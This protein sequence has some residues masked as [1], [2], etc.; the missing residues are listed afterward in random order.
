MTCR[1]WN[2]IR[3]QTLIISCFRQSRIPKLK[4]NLNGL[5]KLIGFFYRLINHYYAVDYYL[6]STEWRVA[7]IL[8]VPVTG[9]YMLITDVFCSITTS[10]RLNHLHNQLFCSIKHQPYSLK[11]LVCSVVG[12]ESWDFVLF[13]MVTL[14]VFRMTWEG[15]TQSRWTF[16]ALKIFYYHIEVF[17]AEAVFN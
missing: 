2:K 4:S 8:V 16:S 13:H 10:D 3:L 14:A 17:F 6:L 9:P 11:L 5:K 1:M 12:Q 7:L 15:W